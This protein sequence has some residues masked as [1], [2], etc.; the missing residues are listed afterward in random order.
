MHGEGGREG[1]ESI[2][3]ADKG[4]HDVGVK[5]RHRKSKE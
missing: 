2:K 1:V 4:A 3:G 5:M